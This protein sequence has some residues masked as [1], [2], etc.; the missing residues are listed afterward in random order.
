MMA[1]M[2]SPASTARSTISARIIRQFTAGGEAGMD[3]E[4]GPK[5]PELHQVP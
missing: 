4:I 1:M 2:S 5:A 3:M